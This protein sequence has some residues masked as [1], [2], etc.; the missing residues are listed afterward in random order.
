M[1]LHKQ[2]ELAAAL[3]HFKTAWSSLVAASIESPEVD[4]SEKYPL[5][6]LDF[7][8]IEPAVSQWC[9]LHA[10]SIMN[11][12]ADRVDNPICVNC[13]YFRCGVTPSGICF[14][15][16][17]RNCGV[18]PV[19]PFSRP[20]AHVFM[21]K[22]YSDQRISEMSD[23]VMQLLYM[24]RMEEIYERTQKKTE[25]TEKTYKPGQTADFINGWNTA[26]AH[27]H[28]SNVIEQTVGDYPAD[29][30][31]LVRQADTTGTEGNASSKTTPRSKKRGKG[32]PDEADC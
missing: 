23:T 19:I 12:M 27:A 4:L 10:S 30:T 29:Y 5:Y 7:E 16:G 18:N 32:K 24:E 2:Y 25:E 6:L 31:E 21:A 22:F 15:A 14:G 20:I 11:T 28:D 9:T 17:E 26:M 3:L 13:Y 1:S 8:V